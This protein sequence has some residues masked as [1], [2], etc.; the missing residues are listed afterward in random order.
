MSPSCRARQ[1]RV[2]ICRQ[3]AQYRL[4]GG[5]CDRPPPWLRALAQAFQGETAEG[6]WPAKRSLALK[7]HDLYERLRPIGRRSACASINA[8]AR[9]DDR[10][11]RR[12]RSPAGKL[13]VKTGGGAAGHNGIR[14]IGAHVGPDFHRVRLGVGHPGERT[15]S[16]SMCWAISP[17]PTAA[18]VDAADRRHRRQRAAARRRRGCSF[19]TRS[20]SRSIPSP[21]RR[22]RRAAEA[23]MGFKCGIVGLP[24]VGKSTLF[25][26][27]TRPRRRRRPTI[28]S[29]PSS[30]TSAMSRC[31]I[32][33]STR[34]RG[35]PKS[36]QIIPTRLTFVDIAGLVRGASKGEGLGNQFLA[37]IREIDAIAHVVRCFEDGDVTHVEGKIDPDRRHRDDRDRADA[38]RPRQ[39]GEARRPTREE[40][41]R[42]G[43]KEAKETVR[44][45]STARWSLLREGKPARLVE[46][47]PEEEQAFPMPGPADVQAG[48][49]RVQ[50]R[51]SL[52][53][54]GQ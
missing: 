36:A 45:A 38:G 11:P 8:R 10:A 13:R 44:A 7:P 27:L 25:N 39:P 26:A 3:P 32:R 12:D 22:T 46:R 1:S 23:L 53:R 35:S 33:A 20:I 2:G 40:G 17:R 4:H 6:R 21:K 42:G 5:G 28:P 9:I 29:A 14:S 43:D 30:P 15:A 47:K 51:G 50:C 31:P 41:A 16:T 49:L 37:N 18:W 48:A 19:R 52:R 34:W 24:N 54:Q